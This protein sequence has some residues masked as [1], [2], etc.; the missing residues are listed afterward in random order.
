[1]VAEHDF[2]ASGEIADA[3]QGP[4][5]NIAFVADVGSAPVYPPVRHAGEMRDVAPAWTPVLP[6]MSSARKRLQETSRRRAKPIG[7]VKFT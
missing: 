7:E 6:N 2:V 4:I 5:L 3:R 1:M